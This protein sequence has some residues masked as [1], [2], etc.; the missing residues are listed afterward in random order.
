MRRRS[1]TLKKEV[2]IGTAP[3][4]PG[5]FLLHKVDKR[6]RRTSPDVSQSPFPRA[7]LMVSPHQTLGEEDLYT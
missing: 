7:Q 3:T 5:L 1:Q 2:G 6:N 4:D